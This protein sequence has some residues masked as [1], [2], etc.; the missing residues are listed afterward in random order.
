MSLHMYKNGKDNIQR[1]EDREKA[2]GEEV[3]R[4]EERMEGRK[5]QEAGEGG[6]EGGG[7]REREGEGRLEDGRRGEKEKSE[8]T[9]RVMCG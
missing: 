5:G 7:E 1:T 8:T 3:G 4:R 2:W 9:R 6:R